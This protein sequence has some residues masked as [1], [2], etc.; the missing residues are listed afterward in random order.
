MALVLTPNMIYKQNI[1][2]F[3]RNLKRI[4]KMSTKNVGLRSSKKRL[5]EPK[6][7]ISWCSKKIVKNR[8]KH[9]VGFNAQRDLSQ[10]KSSNF[11]EKSE[12]LL[13]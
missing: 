5:T 8:Q 6:N 2:K 7:Q 13:P 10:K 9:G 4:D 12:N 1:V 3:S 11:A